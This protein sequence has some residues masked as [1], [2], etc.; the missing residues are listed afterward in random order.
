MSH[1]PDLLHLEPQTQIDR[2]LIA[3][4]LEIAFMGRE[5]G[6]RLDRA[7]AP[8]SPSGGWCREFFADDL[9]LAELV[10]HGFTLVSGGKEYRVNRPALVRALSDPPSTVEGVRFRQEILRELDGSDDLRGKANALYR[11]LAGL[12][13]LLRLPGQQARID[14][15]AFRLEVLKQAK[16]VVDRMAADFS[17]ATSGLRRLHDWACELRETDEW[18]ELESLLDYEGH[19]ASLRFDI[20]IG[21][22]GRITGLELLGLAENRTNR[23]YEPPWRR[24]KRRVAFLFRGYTWDA[25]RVVSRLVEQVFT[26]IAPRLTMVL[27]LVGH[28]EFYLAAF[29]LRE[30][31][32]SVGLEMSLPVV[33]ASGDLVLRGLFN[34]LLLRQGVPVACELEPFSEASVTVVTGPNSGGKTRLLQGLALAQLLGQSGLFVPA[35]EARLRVVPGLFVSLIQRESVDQDEGRLGRE[36]LR[37]RAILDAL[38][39]GGM[40][41]FDELCSG[42]NPSEGIEV[43]GVVLR[44]LEK[45]AP[46]GFICTH[47]L[48]YARELEAER[49]VAGMR[50][51]QVEVDQRERSTYQFVGGVAETSLAASI[52]RRLGVTFE[53]MSEAIDRRLLSTE[54]QEGNPGDAGSRETSPGDTQGPR[55][56]HSAG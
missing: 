33:E 41:V 24:L 19:L 1:T 26:R 6:E 14:L 39:P 30:K 35:A 9:F 36:L 27:E 29:E 7:L 56:R 31:A 10:A 47:F 54:L 46:V 49:P 23:F 21:A 17:D 4:L 28:L 15:N 51:L 42:T 12:A 37:I 8:R 48:D 34:P 55:D 25:N 43:F 52:A 32:R 22:T 2:D 38:E 3:D 40:V 20:R 18:K 44:L 45:M 16:S 5:I 13:G 11:D 53:E 50:F